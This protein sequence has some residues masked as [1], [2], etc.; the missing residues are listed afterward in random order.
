M[1]TSN[2]V[3]LVQ[4]HGGLGNQMFQAAAGIALSRRL[5]L[6][7]AFDLSRFR[8]KAHKAYALSPF[9]IRAE[10]RQPA[11]PSFLTRAG[12][13]WRRAFSKPLSHVP[14]DWQ[15]AV[16]REPHFHYDPCF[17][18]LAGPVLLQGY[19]QSP[20]YFAGHEHAIRKAFDA[21]KAVS[22]KAHALARSIAGQS[23]LAVH[24]RRGDMAGDP[25]MAAVHGTLGHEYYDAAVERVRETDRHVR[26]FLFSDDAGEAERYAKRYGGKALRGES[27]LDDLWLMCQ[28]THHVIANS[29][30]SW[31]S[32]FLD[33]REGGLRI[34]P[35]LWFAPGEIQNVIVSDLL[36][37]FSL[38]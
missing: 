17:E 6:P 11:P 20:R 4:L 8:G 12:R 5:G 24:V 25:K 37:A 23:S 19:F 34:A 13:A 29:S 30:F 16:Y 28:C 9:E 27:A 15:G 14:V 22:Q 26:I 38:M 21:S 3:V 31:W 7:L 32:A 1:N 2:N 10:I 35:K 33:P 18:A 36:E